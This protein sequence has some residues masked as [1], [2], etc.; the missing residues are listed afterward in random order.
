MLY[1]VIPVK[2]RM[3]ELRISWSWKDIVSLY[4]LFFGFEHMMLVSLRL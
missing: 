4:E 2:M 1:V 3:H